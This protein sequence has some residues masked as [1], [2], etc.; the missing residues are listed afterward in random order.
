M[1][2]GK[3][4]ATAYRITTGDE[5]AVAG[6]VG[7]REAIRRGGIIDFAEKH[8]KALF[9]VMSTH[10]RLALDELIEAMLYKGSLNHFRTSSD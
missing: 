5:S 2:G 4:R 3:R 8:A 10:V 1:R 6:R 9:F 7:H